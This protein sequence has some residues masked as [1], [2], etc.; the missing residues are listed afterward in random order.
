MPEKAILYVEDEETDIM[1][2]ECA[3][4]KAQISNPLKTV[5]NGDE[6]VAY[7]MGKG[8]YA[9]RAQHPLPGLVLLDLNLPRLSG[10]KV[11][12]WIREQP[13]FASLPVVI[14]T[15]SEDPKQQEKAKQLG[16]NDYIV[17]P[18]FVDEIAAILQ[19]L[20]QR[21]LHHS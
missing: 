18:P 9:D 21:W 10:M 8:Q 17:K 3:L 7:L 5:K 13:Q 12:Q 15:S 14:Y 6:A 1:L 20:K 4:K 19:K 16:A 2:V 11:L